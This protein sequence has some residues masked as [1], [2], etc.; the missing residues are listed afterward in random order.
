ML[1]DGGDALGIDRRGHRL[2]V[3]RARTPPHDARD[4]VA[5]LGER[6]GDADA[7]R[8][9]RR[10]RLLPLALHFARV[11]LVELQRPHR[12]VGVVAEPVAQQTR[13]VVEPSAPG[14][15]MDAAAELPRLD[16]ALPEVPVEARRHGSRLAGA[17]RA[18]V[19]LIVGRADVGLG[20][21]AEAPLPDPLAQ[22]AHVLAGVALVAHLRGDLLRLGQLAELAGLVDVVAQRLLAVDGQP[23]VEGADRWR[24]SDCDRAWQP[25]RRRD[26]SARRRACG[27]RCRSSRRR[28]GP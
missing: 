1:G 9:V 18:E 23:G 15:R 7:V 2:V 22:Q 19:H 27:S 10:A 8:P 13:A 14:G 6:P 3:V 21:V 5:A 20:H 11:G 28:S 12:A 26:V 25:K 16:R 17:A 24:G 4:H